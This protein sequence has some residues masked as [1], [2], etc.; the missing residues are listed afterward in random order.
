MDAAIT[1]TDLLLYYYDECSADR[2]AMID[3]QLPANPE[4]QSY[5]NSLSDLFHDLDF[6][7]IPNPTTVNIVLEESISFSSPVGSE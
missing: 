2:K 4:W 7:A 1:Q 3:S 5:L 6:V